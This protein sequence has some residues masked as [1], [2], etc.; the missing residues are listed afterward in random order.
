M[1]FAF[2]W[3]FAI[4]LL[5]GLGSVASAGVINGSVQGYFYNAILKSDAI[6]NTSTAQWNPKGIAPSEIDFSG[7]DVNRLKNYLRFDGATL[8]NAPTNQ[9]IYLGKLSLTSISWYTTSFIFG[10]RLRL[11]VYT[12]PGVPMIDSFFGSVNIIV[13]LD[14]DYDY[15]SRPI[16]LASSFTT[17]GLTIDPLGKFDPPATVDLYGTIVGDPYF[18]PAGFHLANPQGGFLASVPEPSSL[19]LLGGIA[20]LVWWRRPPGTAGAAGRKRK[21]GRNELT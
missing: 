11:D 13:G 4:A 3:M 15:V 20:A 2:R 19:V 17:A 14:P 7:P 21:R 8:V 9:P 5:L 18:D 6:D 16:G 1:S 10:A 12:P